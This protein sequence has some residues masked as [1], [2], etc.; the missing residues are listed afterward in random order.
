MARPYLGIPH[1]GFLLPGALCASSQASRGP[2]IIRA[3]GNSTLTHNF[4]SLWCDALNERKAN[5]I[6]HFAMAHYDVNPEPWWIDKLLVEMDRVEADIL[7][8]ILPIKDPRGLTSTGLGPI[9]CGGVKR[10]T[11]REVQLLPITFSIEHFPIEGFYLAVNTGLWV[12]RIDG[13]WPDEFPGF[14]VKNEIRRD[15]ETG[16]FFA[17]FRPEDWLFSD[18]AHQQGLRVCATRVVSS[19]HWGWAEYKNDFPWGEWDEDLEHR[20]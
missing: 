8:V 13:D 7:S 16:Q 19:G 2:I 14:Q 18:W 3:S 4:N 17:G 5:G 12:A 15:P 1:S 11:V 10:L 6:T 20:G 9:G